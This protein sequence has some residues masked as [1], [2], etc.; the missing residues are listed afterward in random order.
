MLLMLRL[1]YRMNQPL[2]KLVFAALFMFVLIGCQTRSYYIS[3]LYGSSNTYKTLPFTA[4]STKSSLYVNGAFNLSGTNEDL[5]DNVFNFQGNI[6][7]VHQ[8]S[9]VKLFYGAGLGA[10]SY[11]VSKYD[12]VTYNPQFDT[13]SINKLAGGK[14]F[15]S[16]N[17][18]GGLVI[19]IP[20][21][22]N[23][24]WRILGISATLQ[25]EF[26]SYL[27]F[28]NI[29]QRDSIKVNGI[30][31]SSVLGT[32]NF[33]TEFAFKT[34]RG[35]FTILNQFTG[36]LGKEYKDAFFGEF[37]M[38]RHNYGYWTGTYSYTINRSTISLTGIAGTRLM[39]LQLGYN[40]SLSGLGRRKERTGMEYQPF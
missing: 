18:M 40:H 22:L 3:P 31:K 27:H 38:E 28:R 29:V 24:E 23:F 10:G 19:T 33:S 17:L 16:A 21:S 11:N 20:F 8:L 5:R 12:T 9:I 34:R 6:Y 37:G 14:F 36:L 32:L 1:A 30:A 7:N 2:P 15:G 13:L 4:D 39:S 25:K 26:G 35:Q